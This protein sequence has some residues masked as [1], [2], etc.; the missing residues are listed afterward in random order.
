M[1]SCIRRINTALTKAGAPHR[2]H[3][4]RQ[5]YYYLYL[6]D[7]APSGP[8]VEYSNYVWRLDP[9]DYEMTARDINHAYQR[10]GLAAPITLDNRL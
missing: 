10:A 5:G 9:E 4:S 6:I 1:L 3:R 2:L 7:G 8:C